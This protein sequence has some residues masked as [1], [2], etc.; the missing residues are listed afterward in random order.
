[1]ENSALRKQIQMYLF[2]YAVTSLKDSHPN[3]KKVRLY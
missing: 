1:M 3:L 2:G